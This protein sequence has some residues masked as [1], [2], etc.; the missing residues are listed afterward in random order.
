MLLKRVYDHSGKQPKLDHVKVLRAN[1]KQHFSTR[2]VEKSTADGLMSLREGKI[3]LH[4][5]PELTYRIVRQPGYYCCHCH[6]AVDDGASAR[7][8]LESQHK[9]KKSPDP[10]NPAGYRRDNFY[11]C[12]RVR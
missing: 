9:G 5:R 11:A 2:F 7:L 3:I 10:G 8:H 12:E 1:D 6:Q 4:T